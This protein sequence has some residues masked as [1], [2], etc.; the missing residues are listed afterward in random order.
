M[1]KLAFDVTPPAWLEP[2]SGG[3]WFGSV[4]RVS[5]RATR[6]GHGQA[7]FRCDPAGLAGARQ[8]W[9]LVR[10]GSRTP[11]VNCRRCRCWRH[12]RPPRRRRRRRGH[13]YH[14]YHRLRPNALRELPALS[15]LAAPP[16]APA[17]PPPPGAPLPPV[18]TASGRSVL[19]HRRGRHRQFGVRRMQVKTARHG[20]LPLAANGLRALGPPPPTRTSPS[21]RCA[22][23]ASQNRPS[24]QDLR[25]SVS[26]MT[27]MR[28]D[29]GNRRVRCLPRCSE[30]FA[31]STR[32]ATC[33]R[34]CRT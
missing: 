17:P 7:G 28:R 31:R 14:R 23:H 5:C 3:P 33:G 30:R 25:A 16:S 20:R 4:A 19:H 26:D 6:P 11:C 22:A 1:A 32:E 2:G 8:W 21:V 18:P 34:R 29:G 9:A 15:V 27:I 10:V 24:R 13:R 12:R